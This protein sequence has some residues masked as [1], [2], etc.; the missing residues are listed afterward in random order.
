V[1]YPNATHYSE[2]FSRVELDCHCG[3]KTPLA[4][5]QNLAILATHLEELRAIAG[6]ALT[7]NCAYRCPK[8]NAE[9]GGKPGS[10]H[11]QGKAADINCAPTHTAVDTFA[12][13]AEKVPAFKAAG[14][15]RYYDG[16]GFF[17]HVD[18]G[19]RYWRGING[20]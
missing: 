13:L 10:F 14:I 17:V 9:V 19:P 5:A 11:M 8:R 18:F 3:C 16:H 4:V 12:R 2:H 6:H 7:P 20:V 15:G 1:T